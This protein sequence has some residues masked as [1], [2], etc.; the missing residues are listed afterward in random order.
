MTPNVYYH[1]L[2]KDK[3]GEATTA[4]R[5]LLETLIKSEKLKLESEIPLKIHTGEPGNDTF[6]KPAIFDGIIDYLI[7]LEISPYF[8]ESNTASGPRSTG[9]AHR[10]IAKDHGF[11]R[12]PLVI[13]DGDG[14]DHLEVAISNGTHFAS[15]K[16]ATKL[17]TQP[18]VIVLS[19]FKGHCM[20]G[21]GG[22]IKM[23]GL[24][25]A[26]GRG[27]SELHSSTPLPSGERMNWSNSQLGS[28]GDNVI[29]NPEVVYSGAVFSER[30]AEYALAATL[31]KRHLYLT[32]A[33]D[34]TPNCDCDGN[35]MENKYED[36]GIF[37]STDPVAID[38]AAYDQL[39]LREGKVPF[40]GG[41]IFGYAEKIGL[42][43][44]TYSLKLV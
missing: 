22:A 23:L 14:F 40:E 18:Q 37:A 44:A 39:A 9:D 19:H 42:G 31:G 16:I 41:S 29:W 25:F 8:V 13:A 28:N 36:L 38:K 34:I 10:Q 43:S 5:D 6:V 7:Q 30:V 32:F 35:H 20:T 3:R 4:A 11:T 17:A 1:P 26:S 33:H 27:K 21:F 24:G 12:I 2:P 15:C